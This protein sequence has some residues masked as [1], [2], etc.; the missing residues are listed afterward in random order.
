MNYIENDL[1]TI[2][3]DFL[4]EKTIWIATLTNGLTI[5][6]DD[7][8]PNINEYSA[9]KRLGYYLKNNPRVWIKNFSLRFR[10]HLIELPSSDGYYFAHGIRALLGK[11][12]IHN[13]E[14]FV[15][16]ILDSANTTVKLI[17]FSTPSLEPIQREERPVNEVKE[18]YFIRK[19]CLNSEQPNQ[20]SCLNTVVQNHST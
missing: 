11:T 17:W 5:Y 8:R 9:W 7:G 10:S 6:Q 1:C 4:D 15:I 19:Q 2:E 13:A 16:G 18:P 12:H 20:P 3:D 14:C